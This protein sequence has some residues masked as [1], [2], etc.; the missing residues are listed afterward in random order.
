MSEREGPQHLLSLW[1]EAN[2]HLPLVSLIPA[3]LDETTLGEP[4]DEFDRA[5]MREL[6]PLGQSADG[7]FPSLRQPL[8]GQEHLVLLG[9]KTSSTRG[10]FGSCG[11]SGAVDSEIRRV[12]DTPCSGPH[13][14]DSSYHLSCRVQ[15]IV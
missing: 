6:E 5:M 13:P 15:N 11:E 12:F 7:R 1:S 4:S 14:R 10:L 3:A 9:F 2:K 8:H